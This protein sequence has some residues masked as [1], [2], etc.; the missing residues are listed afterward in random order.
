VAALLP[1]IEHVR[2]GSRLRYDRRPGP[3]PGSFALA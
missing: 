3:P 1:V 2:N